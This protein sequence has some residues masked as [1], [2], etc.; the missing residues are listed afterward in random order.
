M[1][2]NRIKIKLIVIDGIY[3]KWLTDGT[4][5]YNETYDETITP[6]IQLLKNNPKNF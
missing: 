4:P 5:S 2:L 3:N 1:I 6:M